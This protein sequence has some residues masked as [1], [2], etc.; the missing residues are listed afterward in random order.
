MSTAIFMAA[1]H[2]SA[3]A[4]DK[5]SVIG[6]EINGFLKKDKSPYLVQNTLVVPE[7]KALVIE[8][9]TEIFFNEGTGIDVRGGSLAVVGEH[10]NPVVMTSAEGGKFWNGVSIT[11]AK[12]S[13]MQ[14]TN[15][16]NATFGIAVESGTLE[17]RDGIIRNAVRAAVYV[18]NGAF[19][20][21]WSQVE[22]CPHA[23]V[24]ASS[25]AVV[26][27]DA[28]SLSNNQIAVVA[29]EAKILKKHFSCKKIWSYGKIVVP[30]HAFFAKSGVVSLWRLN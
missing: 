30:L 2:V 7:G 8:A 1:L 11:G 17:V 12:R 29:G 10:H 5:G 15:I 4:V 19:S 20:M 26:D 28:T 9:G 24:W 16:E 13:E 18:R 22:D 3:F 25:K 21:Q 6:G 14:G 27:I 23:G